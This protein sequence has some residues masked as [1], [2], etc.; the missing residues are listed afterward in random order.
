MKKLFAL[1]ILLFSI[2]VDAQSDAAVLQTLLAND[3]S[4]L[5]IICSYPDSI[6]RFVYIAA[7]YPQGFTRLSEIQKT[8]S[9]SFKKLASTYSQNRQKQLWDLSRFPELPG[10]ILRQKDNK[11]ALATSLA[12]YPEE[13]K[14]AGLYFAKHSETLVKM[15]KIRL[16][17]E[18]QY[19]TLVKEFP[20]E[21]QASFQTLLAD[22]ELFALLSEDLH[23]TLTVGDLYKRNAGVLKHAADSVH[24]QIAKENGQEYDDWKTG[25]TQD[26]AMQKELKDVTGK[27]VSEE[28]NA[29]DV[30]GSDKK[31]DITVIIHTRPYPY[32]AGYPHWYGH[33]YWRPYPWWYQSGFYWDVNGSLIFIGLPT[34]QFG[35]WYYGH[36]N[37]YRHYHRTTRYFDHHYQ[38]HPRSRGGFNRSVR[39]YQHNAPRNAPRGTPNRSGGGK[40]R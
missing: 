24:E 32:W 10:L 14:K 4:S 12:L 31:K 38:G 13:T 17:F 2:R 37:Y 23:T 30:Y 7:T 18:S 15:D 9:A 3:S 34:Y 16:D 1:A 6:R 36:P 33:P 35:W 28:D 26:T 40:R 29:D 20:A 25:I 19:K 27:Y 8:S 11:E 22:P 5:R 21:V 39:D